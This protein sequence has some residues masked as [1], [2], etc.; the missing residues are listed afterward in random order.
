MEDT[1]EVLMSTY[2]GAKFVTEQIRSI[3][4][5]T[6]DTWTMIISDDVSN[7]DTYSILARE[8]AAD[9]RITLLPQGP[10]NMGAKAN[11]M[12]LLKLSRA[13]Y[14][15]LADQDDIWKPTKLE[16]CLSRMKAVERKYGTETPL[17]V[18]TDMEVVA[19]DLAPISS[20]VMRRGN[21]DCS[22]LAF[23]ELV[24]QNIAAGCSMIVNRALVL[25]AATVPVDA[26]IMMHEWWLMLVASKFGRINFLDRKLSLYRQHSK[27]E[28]GSSAYSPWRRLMSM[29][30][31]IQ[32][33]LGTVAQAECFR[34]HYA[35]LLD[36]STDQRLREFTEVIRQ[37][38]VWLAWRS[39]IKSRCLKGGMR[40]FGQLVVTARLAK[41]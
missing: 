6:V 25:R 20:S 7:D 39:L 31:M 36:N 24:A 26:P 1:I 10:R 41:T 4:R 34:N 9:R 21:F 27:N 8:A 30:F 32:Q 28:V 15:F 13:Q 3:Q 12:R 22:R 40:I 2:N 18:F 16:D 19:E 11:F 33:F 14:V 38:S 5:Q 29:D 23:E 37:T 35:E 17:L